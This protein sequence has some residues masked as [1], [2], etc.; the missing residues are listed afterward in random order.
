MCGVR[1]ALFTMLI[2]YFGFA[3][4]LSHRL[5]NPILTNLKSKLDFFL[6]QLNGNLQPQGIEVT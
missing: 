2:E 3:L 1:R 5:E 6:S 4:I